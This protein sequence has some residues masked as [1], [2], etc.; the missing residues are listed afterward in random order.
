MKSGL[1]VLVDLFSLVSMTLFS[2]FIIVQDVQSTDDQN[3]KEDDHEYEIS[4]SPVEVD[5]LLT[6]FGHRPAISELLELKPRF[7][8]QDAT[9]IIGDAFAS[10]IV[11]YP[12]PDSIRV[13]VASEI[14]FD[15]MFVDVVRVM[16]P[17]ALT[18][19]YRVTIQE[20]TPHPGN[21]RYV[22]VKGGR[23]NEVSI[24]QD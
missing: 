4:V 17:I 22:D 18:L 7:V 24:S 1:M 23:W 6:Y 2:V 20:Q 8:R 5:G 10:G 14:K 16:H 9:D 3:K 13:F 11:V 21:S 12:T 19:N 15:K